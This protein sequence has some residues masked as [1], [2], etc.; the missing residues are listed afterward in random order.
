[1]S[2]KKFSLDKLLSVGFGVVAEAKFS[3]GAVNHF[4]VDAVRQVGQESV[5]K[6]SG[7]RVLRI[8]FFDVVWKIK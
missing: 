5:Q 6:H 4:P 1:M 3:G 8:D 7:R 2:D